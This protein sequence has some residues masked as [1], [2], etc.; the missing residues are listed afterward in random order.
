MIKEKHI[1][2]IS[3]LTAVLILSILVLPLAETKKVQAQVPT[4]S[5]IPTPS[6]TPRPTTTPTPPPTLTPT[7]TPTPT[8]SPTVKPSSTP[9]L[10]PTL[11]NGY[12]SP[13]SG[14]S[15][16]TFTYYVSYYD[17]SATNPSIQYVIIDNSPHSMGIYSGSGYNGIYRYSTVL[18]AGSHTYYFMFTS[19]SSGQTLWFGWPT[20]I[21]GP[22]VTGPTPTPSPPPTP[23]LTNGFVNPIS[24]F[25]FTTYTFFVSYYDPIGATPL[26]PFVII[27]N[28]SYLMSL[29]SG[30]GSNGLYSYGTSSLLNGTH[31]FYFNF[32]TG[33]TRQV[34]LLA[35][36]NQI[37]GPTVISPTPAPTPVP[38]PT[39][40]PTPEPTPTPPPTEPPTAQP[41]AIPPPTP[42]PIPT[43]TPSPTPK[44][45]PTQNR[46]PPVAAPA[47]PTPTATA[48]INMGTV[49]LT[50]LYPVAAIAAIAVILAALLLTLKARKG[51]QPEESTDDLSFE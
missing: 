15:S 17:P 26:S 51:Q 32:T 45:M 7:P 24:G 10:A 29:Y 40:E 2:I 4:S 36:P 12:V 42:K 20:Q 44:P 35:W 31:T 25:T 23:A 14:T 21:A 1:F 39:P 3:F 22:A 34:L 41:T 47:V 11:S 48:V 28:T 30:N 18:A 50:S 13:T 19:G 43:P 27:D 33:S 49:A 8:P 38:T 5:P 6:P 16:T 37:I 46:V 9:M